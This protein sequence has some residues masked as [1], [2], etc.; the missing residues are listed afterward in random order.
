MSHGAVAGIAQRLPVPDGIGSLLPAPGQL[1]RLR[2][3]SGLCCDHP[4]STGHDLPIL[5]P[6]PGGIVRQRLKERCAR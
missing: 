3:G 5:L 4:P 6:V 2:P 1:Q